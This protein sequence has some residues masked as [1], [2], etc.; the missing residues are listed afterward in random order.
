MALTLPLRLPLLAVKK[1]QQSSVFGSMVLRGFNTL[2]RNIYI[3]KVGKCFTFNVGKALLDLV[4][5]C[6]V[7]KT[8]L[9]CQ[10]Y[11]YV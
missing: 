6:C 7:G 8:E 5:T 9:V 2:F 3:K 1:E 10:C 11:M 4:W